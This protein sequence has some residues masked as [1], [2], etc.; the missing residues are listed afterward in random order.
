MQ[1]AGA[2]VGFGST[3]AIACCLSSCADSLSEV[4]KLASVP[5]ASS[6]RSAVSWSLSRLNRLNQRSRGRLVR[7]AADA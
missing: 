4:E 3:A 2:K 6:S 7:A 1:K 5:F